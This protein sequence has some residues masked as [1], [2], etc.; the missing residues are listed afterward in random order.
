[1]SQYRSKT[2]DYLALQK[3]N[4]I[5]SA[6]SSRE[7]RDS[8]AAQLEQFC[9]SQQ[10]QSDNLA[11]LI[12]SQAAA[13]EKSF[14]SLVQDLVTKSHT[15]ITEQSQQIAFY[16]ESARTSQDNAF[17]ALTQMSSDQ[18]AC[19]Q[20]SLN[21]LGEQ[22]N[23]AGQTHDSLCSDVMQARLSAVQSLETISGSVLTQKQELDHTVS[24]VVQHVESAVSSGCVV[25]QETSS[26][27][28]TMVA[29]VKT[30]SQTMSD[31]ATG[32]IGDFKA[33][34][35]DTGHK[36]SVD[37]T[38]HF[39][40]LDEHMETQQVSLNSLDEGLESFHQS[41]LATEVS[42]TGATPK[43]Q[44]YA[45]LPDLA[46]T[47]SHDKIKGEVRAA[48]TSSQS[49][50]AIN[51]SGTSSDQDIPEY[52]AQ[53]PFED[54]E[55]LSPGAANKVVAVDLKSSAGKELLSKSKAAK[56]PRSSKSSQ[57]S[58]SASVSSVGVLRV[59]TSAIL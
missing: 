30:A 7:L 23:A 46:A 36:L 22:V 5:Q 11:K 35:E 25:I 12:A 51:E 57:D 13:M 56:V 49:A 34:L 58:D 42:V 8:L 15:S 54:I 27:A 3:A 45:P 50:C 38:S 14:K 26:A 2:E 4:S 16:C 33:F 32:S 10:Q 48:I 18:D 44:R 17:T 55:N 28:K 21:K 37:L 24:D 40:E 52:G 47:R 31:K 6:K 29:N 39:Q 41:M 1:M 9:A 59:R 19:F 43:K 53:S 20:D